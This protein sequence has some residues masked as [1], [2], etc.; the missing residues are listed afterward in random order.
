V[1]TRFFRL[2]AVIGSVALFGLPLGA[3]AFNGSADHER[4]DLDFYYAISAGKF[5]NGQ[6]LTGTPQAASTMALITDDPGW[7]RAAEGVWEKDGWF[8]QTSGLALTMSNGGTVVF[9]NNGIEDGTHGDFYN[10]QAQGTASAAT[11]G[12]Y[13][14]Y[15]MANNYDWVY[16]G[17]FVLTE[18]TTVDELNGY[19]NGD[20]YFNTMDPNSFD[21]RMN[22]WSMG[23]NLFPTNTGGFLGDVFNS[24][25]TGGS[26][27]HSYTGVNRVFD[28]GATDPIWRLKY[29]LDA[30]LVLEAGEYWFSHAA[31]IPGETVPEPASM[32]LLATGLAGLAA[33]RRKR[34]AAR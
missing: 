15:S 20:G 8:A 7:G 3:Q 2:A 32:T 27:S 24:D 9:D 16:A 4:D 12:L 29:S 14:G 26:F 21:Y 6:T 10:A 25:A 31:L 28:N 18:R 30:P 19:F 22:I 17:Y 11:P 23:E 33:A 13:T 5:P 34:R 1:N